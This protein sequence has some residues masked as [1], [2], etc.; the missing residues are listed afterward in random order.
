[1]LAKVHIEFTK[2]NHSGQLSGVFPFSFI[3]DFIDHH[4]DSYQF[5]C[6]TII[7]P[8][9]S[10]AK[11]FNWIPAQ[12]KAPCN[13]DVAPR[14]ESGNTGPTQAPTTE[15][16]SSRG[17]AT[18]STAEVRQHFGIDR[19]DGWRLPPARAGWDHGI[20]WKCSGQLFRPIPQAAHV[21]QEPRDSHGP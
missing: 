6:L 9:P 18:G 14:S 2:D 3:S 21:K 15:A 19:E 16:T 7:L 1:M 11:T 17:P 4:T 13:T 20:D 12:W 10:N 8:Q 5:K